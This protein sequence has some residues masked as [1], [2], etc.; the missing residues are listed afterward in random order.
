MHTL[1]RCS[2]AGALAGLL[3]FAMV[4]YGQDPSAPPALASDPAFQTLWEA[5][6]MLGLPGI[7]TVL[8]FWARGLLKTGVPV[9]PVDLSPRTIRRLA[10]AIREADTDD[11]DEDEAPRA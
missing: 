5:G 3:G 7:M 6:K 2:I 1:A 8:G 9:A 10:K 11:T 4:A